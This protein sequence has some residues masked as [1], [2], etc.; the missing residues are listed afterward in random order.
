MPDRSVGYRA[1]MQPRS[2]QRREL[3]LPTA[4]RDAT[5]KRREDG[6]VNRRPEEGV[7]ESLPLLDRAGRR[8]GQ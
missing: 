4:P 8:P 7:M 1:I 6:P 2:H 5:A 3:A